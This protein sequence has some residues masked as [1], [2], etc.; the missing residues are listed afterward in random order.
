M[1]GEAL[2]LYHSPFFSCLLPPSKWDTKTPL[3]ELMLEF[4]N[5]QHGIPDPV[6]TH[7]FQ[8]V[9][10]GPLIV[11]VSMRSSPGLAEGHEYVTVT[12]HA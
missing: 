11:L 4:R 3:N 9:P 1:E 5:F 12:R 6:L 8:Q 2:I 7:L 10:R